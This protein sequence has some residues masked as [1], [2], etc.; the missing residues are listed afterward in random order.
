MDAPIKNLTPISFDKVT[1]GD[2]FWLP[3]I[4]TCRI[5][6]LPHSL[7][8]LESRGSM[9]AFDKAAGM[10][11]SGDVK[12]RDQDLYKVIE[13]AAYVLMTHPDKSL[14]ERID[15]II[16]TIRRAQMP[17][18]YIHTRIQIER[19][20]TRWTC[21]ADDHEL[22]CVGHLIE[23]G[24]AYHQATGKRS[25]LDVALKAT[26]LI[27]ARFGDGPGQLMGYPGH[28]EVE[29]ALVRLW[30]VTGER[31][32]LDLARFFLVNRGSRFFAREQNCPDDQYDH[33][34]RLD[35]IPLLER[36]TIDGHAVRA[37]YLMCGAADAALAT[38][39]TEFID[40][41][42]TVWQDMVSRKMFVTGGVGSIWKTEAFGAPFD[43]PTYNAYQETC[44]SIAVAMWG[45][46]MCQIH[47]DASYADYM[48][49]ALYNSVISSP[50][51]DGRSFFYRNPLASEGA[52]H[53]EKWYGTACCPSNLARILPSIGGFAYLA[54][55]DALYVNLYIEGS[56]KARIGD[57]DIDL[58]I[59][60]DYPW[61][62]GAELTTHLPAPATFDLRLR[63]PSWCHGARASVN[64]SLIDQT[65]TERGYIV[66]RRE[67]K[68]GDSVTLDMPLQI[69]RIQAH[70]EVKACEGH[71]AFMRGPIVY[72]F[73]GCD[74][75]A[76]LDSI[77]IPADAEFKAERRD[78]FGGVV[79]LLGEGEAL[80]SPWPQDELYREQGRRKRISV[81][82]VPY[83]AWDNR[84][85]G[86]MNV[87]MPL[88]PP[89]R[90]ESCE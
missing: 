30:R 37:C 32:Y 51:L 2:D 8:M 81:V 41:L 59:K 1:I 56:V 73:E 7:D 36:R 53:R 45:R 78:I 25:L 68:D 18:G 67:W 34:S 4:D 11:V 79:V 85:A 24:I 13:G 80:E 29:M 16:E 23:A 63:V 39:D 47:A 76:P 84:Q 44:G 33:V 19:P 72:C 69:R 60:T 20:E 64:G 12:P 38:G 82:A 6:L 42:D 86:L 35:D 28:P 65:Q 87:W 83:F 50:S 10:E 21:L 52:R 74:Q 62:G 77:S 90:I 31:R 27:C 54:S 89:V 14:E 57:S 46:R 3:N 26:D 48:E 61:D 49:L 15:G 17:D 88:E 71:S 43:L 40:M 55:S 9:K 75:D 22:Y 58:H 5:A 66:L 70:P